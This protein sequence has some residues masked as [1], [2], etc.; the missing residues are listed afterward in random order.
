MTL[1][2]KLTWGVIALVVKVFFPFVRFFNGMFTMLFHTFKLYHLI[3]SFKTRSSDIFLCT[4]PKSGTTWLQMILYQLTTDGDMDRIEHICIAIPHFEET[5]LNV[6]NLPDRRIFKTHLRYVGMP[7]G[8]KMIYVA[9]D[10]RDVANSF[11][12][13]MRYAK[14]F[15]GSFDAFF[16]MFLAGR[17]PYL[18]W[19]SH[20]AQWSKQRNNPN[21]L[22]LQYED[23]VADPEKA[24]RQIAAFCDI[25]ID[26]AQ[27]PR[28][29]E[30]C[31]FA[32][33]KSHD[34]KLDLRT[35]GLIHYKLH[36]I[37]TD[38]PG[39]IREGKTGKGKEALTPQQ[40]ARYA[41]VFDK[42]LKGAGLDKYR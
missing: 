1:Y 12:H 8:G 36:W 16:N 33:M 20:M 22:F 32:Y 25:P 7:R 26:E 9:R 29:L 19:F 11:Y 34:D 17:V 41:A 24:I 40:Q 42:K 31:S 30:R 15:Q 28:I 3:L 13:H 21:V 2:E 23:M 4:Y 38:A 35:L 18:S 39:L 14:N 5:P 37:N 6:H 27:M 10:G